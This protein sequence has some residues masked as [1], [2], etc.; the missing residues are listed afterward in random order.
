MKLTMRKLQTEDDYWRLRAFLREVMLANELRV[1]SWPATRLDYWRWHVIANCGDSPPV[2]E[3]TWLW[4]TGQGK[5]VAALNPEGIGEAHLQIH[6]A[7]CTDGLQEEM[8][9]V[10]EEHL[11]K[12]KDGK[13]RLIVWAKQA[14]LPRQ[15]I[16][17]R[18][19]YSR[20]SFAERQGRC[21]LS[22]PIPDAPPAQGYTVRS[23]GGV[24]ELP[25]RT[26]VSWW[27]FH[28]DQPDEDKGGW[29]WYLNIQRCPL[30]RRDLDIVAEA[31]DGTL[32]SFCTIWYDDATRTGY[33]EPVGT[34]PR[35][36]RR[37]LGKAVICEGLRRLKEL[38]AVAAHVSSYEPG[39]QKLYESAGFVEAD[40]NEA[41]A[42]T[43]DIE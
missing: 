26:W 3:V 31:A 42:K 36:Q 1:L 4:E 34:A 20:L 29:D 37:G 12:V 38:G 15:R 6:P 16:L 25:A 28:P 32:V 40:L 17:E 39:A 9:A 41:W 18:G 5:L 21:W 2:D 27:A 30:Y 7:F 22:A 23:L 35:H 14:D 13:R 24:E 11:T 33:L 19:G 43:W 8:I 10:A